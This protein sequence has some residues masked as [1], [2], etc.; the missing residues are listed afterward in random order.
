MTWVLALVLRPF[1]ALVLWGIVAFVAIVLIKPLI[2]NGRMKDLLYDRT[3]R[4]RYP[5][6]F[7]FFAMALYGGVLGLIA[8]YVYAR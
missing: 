2:P 7:A 8:W 1:A 3:L 5:W 6:R 4:V